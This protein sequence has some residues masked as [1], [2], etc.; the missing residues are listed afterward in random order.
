MRAIGTAVVAVAVFLTALP[1]YRLTAQSL[2]LGPQLLL[3]D[4]RET[5]S[6]L[7][8]RGVG[9][10]AGVTFTY[11]KLAGEAAYARLSYDPAAD[12]DAVTPF[13][14][15]QFDVRL[16]YYI[17][18]PASAELGIMSRQVDPDFTAQ[19]AGAIRLGVRLSQLVDPAV[20]LHLRGNYLAAARFSGGGSASFG[21]DL[22]M[23]VSGDFARGRVRLSAEY[24]FQHFNRKT[25]DG[26][27]AVAVP[28]QQ[29]V[30]RIGVG[31]NF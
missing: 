21:M 13:D 14:A 15:A 10:G 25:D 27:G 11:K 30:V 18:G 24:E 7:H 23:G 12:G 2:S 26:T 5:S 6:D 19:A 17:A 8:Y 16:R 3:A 28:I 20:R 9:F 4:Y 22:G 29:A 1:P 31:G